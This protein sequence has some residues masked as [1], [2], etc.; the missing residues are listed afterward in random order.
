[1]PGAA[2]LLQVRDVSKAFGAVAAVQG[3]S[4]DL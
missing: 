1:M 2:P 4:F 3:V